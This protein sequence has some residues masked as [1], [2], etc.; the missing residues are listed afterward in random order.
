M[1]ITKGTLMLREWM[2]LT[3]TTQEALAKRLKVRQATV[4]NWCNGTTPT[5]RHIVAI[6]REAGVPLEA[7]AE[8][9]IEEPAALTE[10][11]RTG[12]DGG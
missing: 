4:S 7:W 1:V 9:A 5:A 3:Q 2:R 6:R 12:T 8:P 10:P 11:A